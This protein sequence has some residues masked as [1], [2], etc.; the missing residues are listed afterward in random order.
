[1][2][3]LLPCIKHHRHPYIFN[4]FPKKHMVNI[5]IAGWYISILAVNMFAVVPG[6][7]VEVQQEFADLLAWNPCRSPDLMISINL[8]DCSAW[9]VPT[10]WRRQRRLDGHVTALVSLL[11]SGIICFYLPCREYKTFNSNITTWACCW[12]RNRFYSWGYWRKNRLF[13]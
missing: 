12:R 3:W 6:D 1:M 8:Q 13:S 9:T 2:H 10:T 5:K 11:Q 7:G 4:F